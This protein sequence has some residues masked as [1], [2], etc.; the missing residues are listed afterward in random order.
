MAEEQKKPLKKMYLEE[1]VNGRW[2]QYPVP[3]LLTTYDQYPD[4]VWGLANTQGIIQKDFDLLLYKPAGTQKIIDCIQ[5]LRAANSGE[6]RLNLSTAEQIPEIERPSPKAKFPCALLK[7][8]WFHKVEGNGKR[9]LT[10]EWDP[11]EIALHIYGNDEGL[12]EL[13]CILEMIRN[14]KDGISSHMMFMTNGQFDPQWGEL[15]S[16]KQGPENYI[17]CTY[18]KIWGHSR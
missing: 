17:L 10:V 9:V 8:L 4:A 3:E 2:R 14:S 6:V 13:Q 18:L 7:C 1:T 15:T 12:E 11:E 5:Q 16:E